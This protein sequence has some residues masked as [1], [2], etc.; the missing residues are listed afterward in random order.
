[1]MASKILYV[2]KQTLTFTQSEVVQLGLVIGQS[3]KLKVTAISDKNTIIASAETCNWLLKA[4]P[5]S[6]I[7]ALT[8]KGKLN[9]TFE[10]KNYYGARKTSISLQF[11]DNKT[12]KVVNYSFANVNGSYVFKPVAFVTTD[13]E[14][15]FITKLDQLPID[16]GEKHLAIFINGS[17]YKQIDNALLVKIPK[18]GT[19]VNSG[20]VT[21]LQ[22]TVNVD[23]KTLF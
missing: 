20:V 10:G 18:I 23:F 8:I 6:K 13:A 7:P 12:S 22:D 3:Y 1:M 17:Y 2:P 5:V 11:V 21:Y 16:T 9:Y 15:N 19:Q 4:E 14:G